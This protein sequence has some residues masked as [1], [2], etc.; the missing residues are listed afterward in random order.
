MLWAIG[1]AVAVARCVAILSLLLLLL[2]FGIVCRIAKLLPRFGG[3]DSGIF[4]LHPKAI[5]LLY[6][7][8]VLSNY[9]AS[10]CRLIYILGN[11]GQAR[12]QNG[13]PPGESKPP[14]CINIVISLDTLTKFRYE[15]DLVPAIGFALPIVSLVWFSVTWNCNSCMGLRCEL[16]SP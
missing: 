7:S 2:L 6:P 15:T 11:S 10:F 3:S 14:F 13:R 4:S 8:S 16:W 5:D 1:A 9:T 12:S